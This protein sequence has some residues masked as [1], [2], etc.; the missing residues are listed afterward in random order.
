MNMKTD[1]ATT[2][3]NN[4]NAQLQ[5]IRAQQW[6]LYKNEIAVANQLAAVRELMP[7]PKPADKDAANDS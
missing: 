3:A 1:N 4:L 6:E 7:K 2:L 5:A